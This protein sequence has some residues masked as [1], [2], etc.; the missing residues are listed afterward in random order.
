MAF[1]R[2]RGLKATKEVLSGI[3]NWVCPE[4]GGRMGEALVQSSNARVNAGWTGVRFG[5][6][7]FGLDADRKGTITS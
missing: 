2:L 5:S 6:E 4:C 7:L 1:I 3:L